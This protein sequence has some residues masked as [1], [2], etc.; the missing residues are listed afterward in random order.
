MGARLTCQRGHVF[1]D[2]ILSRND[3]Y[4]NLHEGIIDNDEAG[5]LGV[6][7]AWRRS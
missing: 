1:Q 4:G 2:K 3:N 5:F 6:F 7:A